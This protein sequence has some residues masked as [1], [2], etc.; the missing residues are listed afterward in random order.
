MLLSSQ[1][2]TRSEQA[3]RFTFWYM[4]LGVAQI[5]GGIISFAFQHVHHAALDGWRIMF[6]M[7]GL[8][9]SVVG[10]LT[11]FFIPD[12]PIKASWLTD[13]EKTAL[14]QHVSHNQ[15]GLWSSKLN[16]EQ[17]WEAVMDMQLWL[18]VITTILVGEHASSLALKL[19]C[20]FF[21]CQYPVG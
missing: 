4:G 7:L 9:T 1:Y 5:L 12:T 20:H 21:R 16:L 18:L 13:D 19:T 14:L 11:F 2:Y 3:P 10:A 8:I 15:T 17:I 6:L